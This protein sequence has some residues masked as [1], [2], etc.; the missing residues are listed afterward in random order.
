M[1]QIENVSGKSLIY[2]LLMAWALN[3]LLHIPSFNRTSWIGD[4]YVYLTLANEMQWNLSNYTTAAHP[5][6]SAWPVSIYSQP[7]FHQPPLLLPLIL[8]AGL[9]FNQPRIAALLFANATMG[10]LFIHLLVC[11]RRLK[12]EYG[13][14]VLG[15]LSASFAPLLLF[16]TTRIHTDAT[17]GIFIA[18][19][20]ISYIESLER[21]SYRWAI[22]SATL[23]VIAL[24]LRYTSLICLPILLLGHLYYATGR[25]CAEGTPNESGSFTVGRGKHWR[26]LV[27][28]LIAIG[29]LGLQHY[30]R[31]FFTYHT[32]LPSGF[33]QQDTSA[34]FIKWTETRTRTRNIVNFSLLIPL[35]FILIKPGALRVI[36]RGLYRRDWGAFLVLGSIYLICCLLVLSY[37]EL[38]YFA[39]ATPLF[40]GC[41][42]WVLSNDDDQAQPFYLLLALFSLFSMAIVGY[43][44]AVIRPDQMITIVPLLYE[45]I[46]SLKQFW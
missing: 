27:I 29:T 3:L 16:S 35:L 45:L 13:W 9:A 40:Y 15:L 14:Q 17:A 26:I 19:G 36:L 25:S 30:Y 5:E 23:I 43:R 7:L 38:R 12:V 32:I 10:L 31:I 8:K 37:H 21:N 24:N 33:M 34:A 1:S 42:A 11:W 6:I 44:E 2:F 4:E 20:I 28:F 39:A 18:C 22:W 46:P 41:L